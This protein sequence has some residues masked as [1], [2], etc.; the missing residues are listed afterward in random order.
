MRV[1]PSE[2]SADRIEKTLELHASAGECREGGHMVN[3]PAKTGKAGSSPARH[4][5]P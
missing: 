3:S 1:A 5:N 2:D 4:L